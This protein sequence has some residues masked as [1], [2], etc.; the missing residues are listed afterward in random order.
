VRI[1]VFITFDQALLIVEALQ[2]LQQQGKAEP[3]IAD[4]LRQMNPY[5]GAVWV[6]ET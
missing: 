5:A 3:I 4:L 6:P 1:A 2:R